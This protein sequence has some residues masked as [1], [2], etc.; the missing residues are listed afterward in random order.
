MPTRKPPAVEKMAQ[1]EEHARWVAALE[2]EALRELERE[3]W[4]AMLALQERAAREARARR[5]RAEEEARRLA[6]PHTH[7][8]SSCWKSAKEPPREGACTIM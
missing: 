8:L 7:C 5:E 1:K 2:E 4:L 3:E 6:G